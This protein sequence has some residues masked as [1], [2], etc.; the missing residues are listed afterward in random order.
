MGKLIYLAG[1]FTL[2][3]SLILADSPSQDLSELGFDELMQMEVTSVSKKSEKLSQAAAAVYVVTQ[4]EIRR[5]GATSIPEAL[6]LVPGVDVAEIDPNKWAVSI[7]GFN[8]RFANKLLVLIDGRSVYTPTHSGVYWE[9]LDYLLPDI[10]RIEV[11]RG[12][13]ATLWG[14]NAVNGIINIITREAADTQGGQLALAAGNEL[15]LVEGRQGFAPSEN[16]QLRVYAKGRRLDESDDLFATG[17]DN[18]GDYLQT[19][20]RLDLQPSEDQSLTF[21]GDLYRDS[22]QQQHKVPSFE[23]PYMDQVVNGD[24]EAKGGNL[25]IRWSQIRSLD[26]E[27]SASFNYDFY[28]HQE[29]KYSEHRDTLDFELQ[30]QFAPFADHELVW[31]GGYRWSK[32]DFTSSSLVSVSEAVEYSGIWNLFIQDTLRFPEQNISL[33][34]G[35]KFEGNSYTG[36]EVQPNLRMSWVP[37][38]QVTWWGAVSRAMRTPSRVEN[39][40]VLNIYVVPPFAEDPNNPL[41]TMLQITGNEGFESEQLDAYELG[42][43]WMPHPELALDI[44]TFY[45]DYKNLRSYNLGNANMQFVNGDMFAVVPLNLDNNIQGHSSGLELLTTWQ[46]TPHSRLRLSYSLLDIQLEDTQPNMY[47][48]N[49]LS[50]MADRSSTHQAS[51]WGSFNLSETVELDLRLYYTGQRSW[52]NAVPEVIK[53]NID[54]DLRLAWQ[55]MPSLALSLVGRHLLNSD[56]QQF[57]TESWSS[58]SRIE[59]SVFIKAIL[60]W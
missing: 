59:R 53:N 19:G 30:H 2:F 49:L 33:T 18:G 34:L 51:L 39:E 44:A 29:L 1:I 13:G 31:G 54:G 21:Q 36:T 11:I 45:N 50:L 15:K 5:S 48:E 26:S 40:G 57:Q 56:K 46:A 28:D 52:S 4:D 58:P 16:A 17:Q 43:R 25:G 47:S 9:Y 23:A 3:P 10:E 32:N 27:L 20:L 55:P 37:S 22:L 12:P 14:A 7:R 8:G 42:V 6:R 35:T 38:E 60:S 24:V 41:P